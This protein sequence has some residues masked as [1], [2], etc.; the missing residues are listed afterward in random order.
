MR[1]VLPDGRLETVAGGGSNPVGA[2]PVH[3]DAALLASGP[4]SS[5]EVAGLAIGPNHDLYIGLQTGVYRIT[6]QHMLVH[7]IGSSHVRPSRL[8]AW[9]GNPGNPG[10]F[11]YATRLSFDRRGDLFVVGGGGGWGLYERTTAGAL[12][13]VY[14]LRGGA[15]CCASGDG[16][17]ASEPDGQVVTAS[18]V[19]IQT[20]DPAGG[21]RALAPDPTRLEQNLN[22]VFAK[23]SNDRLAE[24]R[25]GGGIAVAA[26]GT[27]CV[28]A[29][30]GLFSPVAGI[31]T[32][33]PNGH[34]IALWR[35]QIHKF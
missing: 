5:S 26:D 4:G 11:L 1:A 25:P 35:S 27:I 22:Q 8:T 17:I 29:D 20:T 24:F 10:D 23:A 13:F 31:L 21:L 33:T 19:G 7:V 14:V 15:Q 28:D 18:N 30:A 34:V 16:A 9:N 2:R 6:R 12:R 3:A 32:I